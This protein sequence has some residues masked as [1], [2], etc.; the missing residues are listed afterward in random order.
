MNSTNLNIKTQTVE[1]LQQQKQL[2]HMV[3]AKCMLTD[4]KFELTNWTESCR[5][6]G[7]DWMQ[8][9]GNVTKFCEDI[10]QTCQQLVEIHEHQVKGQTQR[11]NPINLP[12]KASGTKA[13]ILTPP[14][15]PQ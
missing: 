10:M 7:N 8:Y 5:M 15:R 11:T 12:F 4:V 1:E 3:S 6:Q 9:V 14:P 13:R 2:L